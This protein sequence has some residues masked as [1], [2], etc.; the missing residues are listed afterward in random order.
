MLKTSAMK[1][2][3]AKPWGVTFPPCAEAGAQWSLGYIE[4]LFRHWAYPSW[5]TCC[6]VPMGSHAE[7]VLDERLR[8]RGNLT[9]LRVA[10]ASVMPDIVSGNTNAPTM[11]IGSKAAEMIIQ[12]NGPE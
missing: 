6:T 3:G 11:M 5:H 9:G 10:D 12:D 1:S 8:V 2:I 4:C 7:A